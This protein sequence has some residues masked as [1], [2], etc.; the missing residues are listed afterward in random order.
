MK[1]TTF[2]SLALSIGL[3]SACVNDRS[4]GIEQRI[5]GEQRTVNVNK[6]SFP[7]GSLGT[8]CREETVAV[9]T[10][11]YGGKELLVVHRRGIP[12]L[13]DPQGKGDV[14]GYNT[15]HVYGYELKALKPEELYVI[16][17]L[18]ESNEEDVTLL[19]QRQYGQH[20]GVVF[21]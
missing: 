5:I 18:E 1:T 7:L 11:A 21:H 8:P 14:V 12:T 4:S 15:L 19:L 6:T 17:P 2:G 16:V 20:L 3:A 13:L 9:Y 10:H